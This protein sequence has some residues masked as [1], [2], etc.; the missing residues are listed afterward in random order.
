MAAD[1]SRS[2]TENKKVLSSASN[3]RGERHMFIAENKSSPVRDMPFAC[4]SSVMKNSCLLAL[5]PR[6]VSALRM[7]K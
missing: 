3:V 1:L 4:A 2:A 6:L 7:K 5:R